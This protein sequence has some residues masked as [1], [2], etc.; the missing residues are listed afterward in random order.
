MYP[1]SLGPVDWLAVRGHLSGP[2]LLFFD[3]LFIPLN[4]LLNHSK[5]FS[6]LML[7]YQICFFGRWKIS[8]SC[9]ATRFG[10]LHPFQIFSR[11][12][13]DDLIPARLIDRLW[14]SVRCWFSG[15]MVGFLRKNFSWLK[16]IFAEFWTTVSPHYPPNLE[17]PPWKQNQR[18]E[19]LTGAV[20]N[21]SDLRSIF[22]FAN[23]V[24]KI[25]PLSSN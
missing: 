22:Y 16:F 4:W 12:R 2:V 11:P 18:L 25:G 23:I 17:W 5:M 9:A 19:N 15:K 13:I 24:W 20:A 21:R 1:L 7:W 10:W 14:R 3:R 8:S 6:D